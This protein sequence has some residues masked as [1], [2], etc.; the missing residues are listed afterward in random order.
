VRLMVLSSLCVCVGQRLVEHPGVRLSWGQLFL[1]GR[2]TKAGVYK[3]VFTTA[4]KHGTLLHNTRK[5][6]NK[7]AHTNRLR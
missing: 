6:E 2:D 4:E 5:K 3:P 7:S 1:W